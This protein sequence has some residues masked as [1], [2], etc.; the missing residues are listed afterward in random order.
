MRTSKRRPS[1]RHCAPGVHFGHA[2]HLALVK[3]RAPKA[4]TV[5]NTHNAPKLKSMRYLVPLLLMLATPLVAQDKTGPAIAVL[6][7]GVIC[8]PESTGTRPAPDT[9]AGVTNVVA[10]EPPFVSTVNK[11][12][13]VIGI[14]FGAKA[15]SEAT[16]GIDN[17]TMTITHPPMGAEKATRQSFQTSISGTDTSITFYQFDYDYELLIGEWTMTATA[18]KEILYSTSFQVV[19]PQQVSELA[20]ICNFQSLL[21]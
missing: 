12:P 16:F 18:G 8:P 11:V 1:A 10:E 14:G 2:F 5:D 19:A 7:T 20:E 15:M 3:I 9:V 17:V 6:E 21:S 13:A 4:A